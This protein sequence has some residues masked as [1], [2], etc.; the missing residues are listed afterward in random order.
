[1]WGSSDENDDTLVWDQDSQ[2]TINLTTPSAHHKTAISATGNSD[3][4]IGTSCSS[5]M[6]R[7]Q[8]SI[9]T[10]EIPACDELANETLASQIMTLNTSSE[11]DVG[12]DEDAKMNSLVTVASVPPALPL[13]TTLSFSPQAL[14]DCSHDITLLSRDAAQDGNSC[15]DELGN[16]LSSP[17]LTTA[18]E[19]M[20]L[21]SF[22]G[23][24]PLGHTADPHNILGHIEQCNV[25]YYLE[26]GD[27]VDEAEDFVE[28][29]FNWD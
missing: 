21:S 19:T 17:S 10:N 20:S 25:E 11:Y 22:E 14:D 23:T 12:S 1:M 28:E 16:F 29:D 24:T 13:S 4:I 9:L 15:F 2:T 8:N 5:E 7:G 6:L 18:D 26:V 27:C 3:T